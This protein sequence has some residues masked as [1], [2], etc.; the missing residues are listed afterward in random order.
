MTKEENE[1]RILQW[2][3]DEIAKRRAQRELAQEKKQAQEAEA[4]WADRKHW[5]HPV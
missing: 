2:W 4:A 1:L 5:C 3:I